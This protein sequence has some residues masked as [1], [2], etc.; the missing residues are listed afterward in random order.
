MRLAV[1]N[2]DFVSRPSVT[3][4][5]GAQRELP[6]VETVTSNF[7]D[8]PVFVRWPEIFLTLTT[9]R[10]S[11]LLCCVGFSVRWPVS[12]TWIVTKYTSPIRAIPSG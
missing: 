2:R 7:I 6:N 3:Y 1:Q 9:I 12:N 8:F 5:R 11:T 10:N 4:E